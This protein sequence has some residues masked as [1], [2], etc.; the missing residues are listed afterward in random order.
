MILDILVLILMLVVIIYV[1]KLNKKINDLHKTKTEIFSLF[2]FFDENVIKTENNLY[3][4]KTELLKNNKD[5][6]IKI[7]ASRNISQTLNDLLVELKK[8]KN[9]AID[10]N[11]ILRLTLNEA[12]SKNIIKSNYLTN[13]NE[14]IKTHNIGELLNKISK[15]KEKV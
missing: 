1:G 12:M 13:N 10:I 8:V 14:Q 9:D 11:K 2:K 3:E 4:I 6:E 15:I 7:N 5:L